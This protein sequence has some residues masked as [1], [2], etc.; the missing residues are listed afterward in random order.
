MADETRQLLQHWHGGDPQA[1]ARL[2]D[3]NLGWIRKRVAN[4]MGALLQAKGTPTDY[5]QDAMVEVLRYGPK[6]VM[7]DEAQFR[8]LMAKIVENVL[9]GRSDWFT[10]ERRAANR[11]RGGASDT[12]LDIDPHRKPVTRPSQAFERD[13]AAE[14]A[15]LGISLLDE[16]DREVII[17]RQ[18]DDLPFGEIAKRLDTTEAAA[19][20]RFER[21]LPKLAEKIA[22]LRSGDIDT[23]VRD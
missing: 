11:E 23:L 13:E 10:A 17:L 8:A 5:V 16:S 15:R 9:R 19:R 4:R 18:W 14:I 6:F 7:T 20:M 21:A 3:R 1:L 2:L 22:L 12:V